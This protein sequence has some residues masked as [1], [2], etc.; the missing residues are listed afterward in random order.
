MLTPIAV[1]PSFHVPL[2]PAHVSAQF[3]VRRELLRRTR[4]IAAD[5]ACGPLQQFCEVVHIQQRLE[6]LQAGVRGVEAGSSCPSRLSKGPT[7][8]PVT[9][10]L[11]QSPDELLDEP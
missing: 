1:K 6:H 2:R 5:G 8:S 7:P 4:N 9:T 11:S 10:V 3:Q